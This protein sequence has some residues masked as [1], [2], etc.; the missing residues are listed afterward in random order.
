MDVERLEQYIYIY[1]FVN[2]ICTLSLC[3]LLQDDQST[4]SS[5]MKTKWKLG[6]THIYLIQDNTLH[7]RKTHKKKMMKEAS[8]H[9]TITLPKHE[10]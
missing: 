7:L 10:H 5:S 2:Y 1:M 4:P 8:N 6:A 3:V 9:E